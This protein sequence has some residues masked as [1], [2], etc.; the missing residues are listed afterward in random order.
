MKQPQQQLVVHVPKHVRRAAVAIMLAATTSH[1]NNAA[2]AAMRRAER[3]GIYI[4]EAEIREAIVA[5]RLWSDA[6]I[7][8]LLVA[9]SNNHKVDV[10]SGGQ[11]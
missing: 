2:G 7:A 10:T 3:D 5:L 4:S 9:P 6:E 11:S 1:V 8:S